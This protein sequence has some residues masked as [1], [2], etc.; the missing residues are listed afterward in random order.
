MAKNCGKCKQEECEECPEW[1]F[2]LA[3]LIMCMMGLF[4]ILWV[5]KPSG[6][7]SAGPSDAQANVDKKQYIELAAAIRNAF[8]YRPD[9]LSDDPVDILMIQ[10]LRGES[11]PRG[12]GDGG[13]TQA[14]NGGADGPDA[15]VTKVREGQVS[16]SGGALL[17]DAGSA[18]PT[19][20][21]RRRVAQIA[22]SLRGHRNIVIVKGHT[23]LDD[24]REDATEAEKMQLSVMRAEAVAKLLIDEGI[25]PEVIRVQGC[26]TFE[27]ARQRQFGPN[28]QVVNRRV[29][30]E[31]TDQLVEDRQDRPRPGAARPPR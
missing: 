25:R 24:L 22:S 14:D 21:V 5:L 13:R 1:I 3:D 31:S 19:G 17:F 29:E 18:E 12:P 26:S 7:P 8:G 10:R 23:S 2:T 9:P 30:I 20:D 28:A 27:P 6:N 4:V 11:F 15:E 16:T